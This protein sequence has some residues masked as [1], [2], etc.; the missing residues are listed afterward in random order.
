MSYPRMTV[1]A[2]AGNS[3]LVTL[4]V[5]LGIIQTESRAA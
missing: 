2:H 4:F 3:F 5:A 1:F